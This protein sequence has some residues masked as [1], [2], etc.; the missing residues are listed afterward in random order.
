M[1]V[2][3][4]LKENFSF[5]VPCDVHSLA[6]ECFMPSPED[7]FSSLQYSIENQWLIIAL[8]TTK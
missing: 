1:L 7:D 2:S 4:T 8:F 5:S 3:L 6:N